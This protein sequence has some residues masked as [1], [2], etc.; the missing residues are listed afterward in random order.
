MRS[1]DELVGRFFF[2]GISLS[3]LGFRPSSDGPSFPRSIEV[4]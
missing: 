1:L 4:Q 3:R 2:F